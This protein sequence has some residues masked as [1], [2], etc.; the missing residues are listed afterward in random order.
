MLKKDIGFRAGLFVLLMISADLHYAKA[1]GLSPEEAL[2]TQKAEQEQEAE[3]TVSPAPPASDE[4]PKSEPVVEKEA[5]VSSPKSPSPPE[6]L[7]VKKAA[8]SIQSERPSPPAPD[9]A[10]SDAD[11]WSVFAYGTI[12]SDP[13]PQGEIVGGKDRKM[14]MGEGDIIYLASFQDEFTPGKEWI[15]Y[16]VIKDV[17]H[18]VSGKY[19][20]DLINVTGVVK[21]TEVNKKIATAEIT[22]S[23]EPIFRNDQIALVETLF[24]FSSPS[25][26][27]LP[28]GLTATVVEARDNRLNNAMHDIVYI[29]RGKKDGVIRGDRFDVIK[30]GQKVGIRADGEGLRFPEREAGSIVVLSSQDHTATAQI[31]R[32]SETISR[33][34]PLLF[35]F[36]K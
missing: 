29:D 2:P 12:L 30:G 18:P 23:K 14:M 17:Y 34:N 35:H 16:R 7:P 3:E 4:R 19:L 31:V 24:D 25:K 33:G 10:P 21:I 8:A 9:A 36:L 15:V 13:R 32:S 5:T 11:F 27:S 22:R 26:R 28:E 6:P 1:D 20:G